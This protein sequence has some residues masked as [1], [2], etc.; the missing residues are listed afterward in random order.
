MRHPARRLA[1]ATA[2]VA[3]IGLA[4]CVGAPAPA[5]VAYTPGYAPPGPAGYVP[6]NPNPGYAPPA[7]PAQQVA[8]SG[9]CYAGVYTCQL[10]QAAGGTSLPY[11]PPPGWARCLVLRSRTLDPRLL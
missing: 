1:A 2:L 6:P 7:P 3:M 8:F 9:T 11:P 10:P 5:P 4:G